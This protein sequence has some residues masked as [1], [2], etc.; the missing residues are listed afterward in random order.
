M[1]LLNKAQARRKAVIELSF[2]GQ[3]SKDLTIEARQQNEAKIKAL[4]EQYWRLSEQ[5]RAKVEASD[6]EIEDVFANWH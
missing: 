5:E 6:D 3:L 4:T 1:I 2:S